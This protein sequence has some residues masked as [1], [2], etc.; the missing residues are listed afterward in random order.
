MSEEIDRLKGQINTF[1]V[2]ISALI[3]VL[4]EALVSLHVRLPIQAEVTKAL[5]LGRSTPE[6]QLLA[7]DQGIQTWQGLIRAKLLAKGLS[8]TTPN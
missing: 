5:L 2:L 6:A 4:P 3:D 1:D 7:F 8:E